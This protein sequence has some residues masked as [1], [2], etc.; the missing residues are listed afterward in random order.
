MKERQTKYEE[1]IQDFYYLT[2]EDQEGKTLNKL[3]KNEKGF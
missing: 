2:S 1:I 3:Y